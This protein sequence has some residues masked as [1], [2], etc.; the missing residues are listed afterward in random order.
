MNYFLI[1]FPGIFLLS[2]VYQNRYNLAK[3]YMY[4]K[5]QKYLNLRTKVYKK[6]KI[7]MLIYEFY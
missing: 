6:Y 4:Y 3:K 7:S 2:V 1:L 5:V